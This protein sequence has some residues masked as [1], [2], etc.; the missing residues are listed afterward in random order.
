MKLVGQRKN[1]FHTSWGQE[2]REG[3]EETPLDYNG[4]EINYLSN[5]II[6]W[7]I[8][9]TQPHHSSKHTQLICLSQAIKDRP[10]YRGKLQLIDLTLKPIN[11]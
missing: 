10:L 11:I 3:K 9:H 2:M 7:S 5:V 8:K 1:S 4:Q 6:L